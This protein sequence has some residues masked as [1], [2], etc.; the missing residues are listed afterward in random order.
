MY[1]SVR[2]CMKSEKIGTRTVVFFV[3]VTTCF[4]G[5]VILHYRLFYVNICVITYFICE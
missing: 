2:V 3:L 1:V 4:F 5:V